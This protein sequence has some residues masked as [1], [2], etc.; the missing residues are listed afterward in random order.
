MTRKLFC[1]EVLVL[2]G[3]LLL[4]MQIIAAQQEQETN[5]KDENEDKIITKDKQKYE[6]D[7][8]ERGGTT[9][10]YSEINLDELKLPEDTTNICC[11]DKHLSLDFIGEDGEYISIG[12]SILSTEDEAYNEVLSRFSNRQSPVL[13]KKM[14]AEDRIG[15]VSFIDEHVGKNWIHA[16]KG[17][18]YL[19]I[20]GYPKNKLIDFGRKIFDL[21]EKGRIKDK[22]DINKPCIAISDKYKKY[23][24][25]HKL[26][27]SPTSPGITIIPQKTVVTVNEEILLSTIITNPSGGK[28]RIRM[29][30]LHSNGQVYRK[31]G[32]WCFRGMAEGRERIS[33]FVVNEIGEMTASEEVTIKIEKPMEETP[34]K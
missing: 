21:I 27:K 34:K 17:N 2:I 15:T 8:W 20:A 12:I 22:E 14:T 1:F 10:L 26:S 19:S 4:T 25:P 32:A 23:A 6:F 3:L 7:K 33:A 30:I 11:V 24:F 9:T 13:A 29:K 5:K 18:C 31:K 16:L 28:V